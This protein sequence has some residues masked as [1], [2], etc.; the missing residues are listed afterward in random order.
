MTET[1]TQPAG[2]EEQRAIGNDLAHDHPLEVPDLPVEVVDQ[3]GERHIQR[4]VE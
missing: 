3:V 1:I 4:S 2:T